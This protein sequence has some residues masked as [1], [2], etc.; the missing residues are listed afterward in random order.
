MAAR[1]QA[2]R[3]AQQ[4]KDPYTQNIEL[5]NALM[6]RQ[7]IPKIYDPAPMLTQQMRSMP[8]IALGSSTTRLQTICSR[9]GPYTYCN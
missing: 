1:M 6:Q 4:N 7:L 5:Q 8:P 3:E 9:Q 2:A